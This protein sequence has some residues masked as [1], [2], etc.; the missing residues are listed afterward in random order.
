MAPKSPFT[1]VARTLTRPASDPEYGTPGRSAWLDVD[2]PAHTHTATIRGT[3]VTYVDI[4]SGPGEPIVFVHGL[5]ACW[6][7]RLE[8]PPLFARAHRRLALDLP[9]L[10]AP[11]LPAEGVSREPHGQL[12]DGPVSGAGSQGAR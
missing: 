10:G 4:G 3:E 6:Q 5:G 7:T 1:V 11:P 8:N 2:W 12:V 9:R